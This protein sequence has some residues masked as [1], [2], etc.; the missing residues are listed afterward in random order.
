MAPEQIDNSNMW[1]LLE[2]EYVQ[3]AGGR[4]DGP[5]IVRIHE[6]LEQNLLLVQF[7]GKKVQVKSLNFPAAVKTK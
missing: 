2:G 6:Y 3:G 5:A 7:G 4:I 1:Q